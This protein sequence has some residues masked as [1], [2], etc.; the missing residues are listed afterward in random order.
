[1][2]E[3][4]ADITHD[5]HAVRRQKLADLRAAGTDPFRAEFADDPFFGRGAQ[6]L[7]RRPGQRGRGGRGGAP[8]DDPRHGQEPVRQD[9]G[10]AGRD[11]ALP[12]EGRHRGRGLCRLQ[13]ARP[14]A[15]SS[16]PG[17]PSSRRRPAR[18]PSGSSPYALLAKALRPLPEKWH[19][20]A[21]PEQVYRQRYLDL[22]VNRESR[23]RLLLRSAGRLGDPPVPRGAAVHRGRDP[24]PPVG[25]R[26]ARRPSPSRPTTTRSAWISSC[27]F[28]SSST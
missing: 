7:R 20:L 26:R 25:R 6:G 3:I 24:G 8:R 10:P 5:Q 15:T 4:P 2:S 16:A 11:P 23:D 17:G 28:R 18:S 12:E 1:M 9:P 27:A 14:R 22:V 19:G 21:D 13:E